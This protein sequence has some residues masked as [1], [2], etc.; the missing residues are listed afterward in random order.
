MNLKDIKGIVD[1]MKK[2]S[3]SEFEMEEGDFKIKLKRE[4]SNG[5]KSEMGVVQESLPV[6]TAPVVEPIVPSA[7]L[8]E[9]ATEGLEVKSPMIG[10]FYRRP[11]PDSDPFVDVG[12]A[13]EPDTIVCIIEAMKVMNEIKAEVKGVIA[14]LLVEDGKPVEYGQALFRIKPN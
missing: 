8:P 9:P 11:S 5:H 4:P 2:N 1:L 3:V 6:V 12:T 10:T 14:E 13:V 7:P